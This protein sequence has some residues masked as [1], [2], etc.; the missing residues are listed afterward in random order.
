MWLNDSLDPCIPMSVYVDIYI[1][2]YT[3]GIKKNDHKINIADVVNF[4]I[5]VIV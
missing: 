1:Y 4:Q 5:W 2:I 3:W